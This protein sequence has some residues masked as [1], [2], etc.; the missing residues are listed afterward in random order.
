MARAR[1]RL[2]PASKRSDS[3]VDLAAPGIACPV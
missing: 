2:S 1:A 3:V